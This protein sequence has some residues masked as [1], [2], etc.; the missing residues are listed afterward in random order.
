MPAGSGPGQALQAIK[1]QLRAV[2]QRGIG[3]GLLRYLSGDEELRQRLG[4]L[5]GAGVCFN[6][7]GQVDR[8]LPAGVGL[9]LVRIGPSQGPRASRRHLLEVNGG[10]SGAAADGLPDLQPRPTPPVSR[11]ATGTRVGG[12]GWRS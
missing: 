9:T 4:G 12:S 11:G 1:E 10:W 3:Y 8:G 5:P 2:P 7:L 6:Y